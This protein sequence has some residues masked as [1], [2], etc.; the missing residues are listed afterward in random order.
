MKTEVVTTPEQL[1]Q[2]LSVRKEVFVQEQGVSVELEVDEYDAAPDRCVHFLMRNA[3]GEA[4]GASRMKRFD[5]ESAKLQRIAILR[6]WRGKGLGR[7]LVEEMEQRAMLDGF[8]YA[9]L[10]AQVQAVPFYAKQGYEVISEEPFYD[11][12]IEHVRM[13][14]RL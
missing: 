9:V 12:G 10:D 3:N 14:K 4:I 11:A 1:E 7:A 6:P 5:A 2:G 13:R 8:K